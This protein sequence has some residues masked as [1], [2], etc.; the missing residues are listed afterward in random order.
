VATERRKEFVL[1]SRTVKLIVPIE[2][3]DDTYNARVLQTF[4]DNLDDLVKLLRIGI[5]SFLEATGTTP[6]DERIEVTF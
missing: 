2:W 1:G 4:E 3:D 6:G 5:A